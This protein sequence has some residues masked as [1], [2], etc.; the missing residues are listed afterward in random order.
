MEQITSPSEWRQLMRQ[1]FT[2]WEKLADFLELDG[3]QRSSILVNP[4]FTLNL[5]MRLAKQI[6]KGTLED[7]ILRQFLPVVKERE[8]A[9]DFM[10]D[11]VGDRAARKTQKLLHKYQ[12]RALLV[13]TS[14]CVMHCR[15]CFRQNYEYETDNTTFDKEIEIIAQDSSIKEVILSGGDP[16][17]LSDHTL[18]KLITALNEI[19]HVKRIRFHTR[20]PVGIPQRLDDSFLKVLE[21]SACQI[22]FVI[23]V[24]HIRELDEELLFYLKRVQQLGIPVLNQ[25]V[26]LRGVNDTVDA[27]VALFE[28]LV[29]NGIM[30]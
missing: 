10:Y 13:C 29:D 1:N 23:H 25:S 19:P 15:Y 8:Q 12:G 18:S 5:P 20:F 28:Q 3:E 26:L 24:N 14:A 30:P 22:W 17:S 2:N 16:L 4:R 9:L 27:L 6:A 21:A 7:P 11:P